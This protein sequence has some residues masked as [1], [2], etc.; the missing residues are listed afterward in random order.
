MM[1]RYRAQNAH[2]VSTCRSEF[3]LGGRERTA[4][5]GASPADTSALAPDGRLCRGELRE[6]KEG[7]E[8][9]RGPER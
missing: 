9:E 1:Y 4:G 7:D 5:G 6:R 8:A 3:E 2:A